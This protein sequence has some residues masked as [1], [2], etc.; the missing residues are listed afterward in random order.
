V[1]EFS[2]R[3][4][5][6]NDEIVLSGFRKID[7]LDDIGMIQLAHDLNFLENVCTLQKM[8]IRISDYCSIQK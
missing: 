8:T 3:T 2:S 6:Q 1:E 5:L 4:K 7:E